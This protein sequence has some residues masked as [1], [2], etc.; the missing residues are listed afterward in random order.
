[1]RRKLW[2]SNKTQHIQQLQTPLCCAGFSSDFL[3]F[4]HRVGVSFDRFP[5]VSTPVVSQEMR[6]CGF[7]TAGFSPSRGVRPNGWDLKGCLKLADSLASQMLSLDEMQE[8]PQNFQLSWNYLGRDRAYFEFE[9]VHPVFSRTSA[10][11]FQKFREKCTKKPPIS[12]QLY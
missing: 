11:L 2:K 9:P 5:V 8:W 6:I 10:F 7:W 1:M 12:P 4:H 3:R